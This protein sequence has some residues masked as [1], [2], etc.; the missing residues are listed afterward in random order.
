MTE[1]EYKQ[2][3]EA[4]EEEYKAEQMRILTEYVLSWCPYKIGDI[5]TDHIGSVRITKIVPVKGIIAGKVDIL[6]FGDNLTKK[7][8]INKT[9]PKRRIYHSNIVMFNKK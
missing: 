2:Q 4:L 3:L 1:R 7:G 9:E 6:M 5:V 8:T